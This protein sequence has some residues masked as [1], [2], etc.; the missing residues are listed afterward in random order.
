MLVNSKS[1]FFYGQGTFTNRLGG[2]YEGEFS[3]GVYNGQGTFTFPDGRQNS[4]RWVNGLLDGEVSIFFR[5][6]W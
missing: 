5:R 3:Q 6:W 4:G 1:D 2:K